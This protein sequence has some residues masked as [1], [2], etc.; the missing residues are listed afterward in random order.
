MKQ[1]SSFMVLSINGGYRISYTYDIIDPET[2]DLLDT[3][4]KESFFVTTKEVS[5]AIESIQ[6]YIRQN[7]LSD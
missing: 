1:L 5:D 4:K 2:G 3:N 7:K 6:G